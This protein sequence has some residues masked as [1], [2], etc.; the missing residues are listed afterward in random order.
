MLVNYRHLADAMEA[1]VEADDESVLV[2]AAGVA[3][4]GQ[5]GSRAARAAGLDR[6][7][8]APPIEQPPRDPE[9]MYSAALALVPAGATITRDDPGC[10]EHGCKIEFELAG[11]IGARVAA[12]RRAL[13]AAGWT[14]V[15]SGRSAPA[16]HWLMA[17]RNDYQATI[18]LVARPLP[19]HCGRTVK[20]GCVDSV[21]VLRVEVPEV[22]TGG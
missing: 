4:F 22:L 3:V 14:N 13:E 12:A 18:E 17:N 7:A 8:I 11:G 21:W 20:W 1:L 10:E 6:C 16:T 2:A 5:R 19:P 15:R 9:H